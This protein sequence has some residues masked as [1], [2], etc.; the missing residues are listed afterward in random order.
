MV[1]QLPKKIHLCRK[2]MGKA[3]IVKNAVHGKH[4]DHGEMG[5]FG[6]GGLVKRFFVLFL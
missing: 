4:H 5:D 2:V 1:L 3:P 6:Y